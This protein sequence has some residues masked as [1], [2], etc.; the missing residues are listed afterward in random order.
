VETTRDLLTAAGFV[1]VRVEIQGASRDFIRNWI[2][3]SNAER[4]VASAAIEA[5][6]PGRR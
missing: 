5:R 6:K 4:Y 1:D 2:P 3:A